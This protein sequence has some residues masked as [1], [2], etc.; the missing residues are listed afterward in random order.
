[1]ELA[2]TL[3]LDVVLV[4]RL[5][6]NPVRAIERDIEEPGPVSWLDRPACTLDDEED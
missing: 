1:L 5:A 6:L 3:E 4:P 2:R